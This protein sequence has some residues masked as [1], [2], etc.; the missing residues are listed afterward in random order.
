MSPLKYVPGGIREWCQPISCQFLYITICVYV[1]LLSGVC[2]APVYLI[3]YQRQSILTDTETLYT[4][5][6]GLSLEYIAKMIVLNIT[7]WPSC[8]ARFNIYDTVQIL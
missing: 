5:S 3:L 2:L 7:A 1:Y 4:C 6:F 8:K